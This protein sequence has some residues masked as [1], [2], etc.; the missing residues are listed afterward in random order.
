MSRNSKNN[1]TFTHL[2]VIAHLFGTV[3]YVFEMTK[4]ER[5]TFCGGMYV[6][7]RSNHI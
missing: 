2:G 5:M 7:Y 4:S 3:R 1:P 6:R